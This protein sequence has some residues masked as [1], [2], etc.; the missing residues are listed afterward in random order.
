M[1]Q[2]IDQGS[3]QSVL[4]KAR[5][6]LSR[7][8]RVRA[9]VRAARRRLE[10]LQHADGHWC[11]EL[12]GDTILESE[13]VLCLFFLGL[14]TDEKVRKAAGYVRSA[15]LAGGGWS[16]YPG[17]PADVSVSIKAYLLLKLAGDDP[18]TPH[19]T[20]ARDRILALGGL[21]ACNS[22][23]KLYLSIFGQYEWSRAPAVVPE[24]ILLPRWFFCNIYA[25]SSWSRAIVVPLSMIWAHKP[26]CPLPAHADV[27]ELRLPRGRRAAAGGGLKARLWGAFFRTVETALTLFETLRFRPMRRR[28]M[29]R[30]EAWTLAHL[31]RSDGLGA[32]F[33]PIVNTLIALSCQGYSPDHP[34]MRRQLSE[35][36]KLEIEEP[37]TLRLQ[38]CKSP[39]WDTALALEALL[40]SG[41]RSDA[42]E[43]RAAARWL[44]DHEVSL[45]GDCQVIHPEI[46][47]GGWYFEYANEHYPDC[48]DTAK[49]LSNL[50]RVRFAE[51]DDDAKR[52]EAV[53]RGRA[54]LEAMQNADGGWA[55]FDKGCDREILTYI[56][57]AD[58][59]AMIDPSTADV[60]SRAVEALL[61][62]GADPAS[63]A[64][65]RAARFLRAEQEA[66]GSWYGRWGCNYVYGTWLAAQSLSRLGDPADGE[67]LERAAGWIRGVQ[68]ADGGWGE[69]PASYDDPAAKGIGPSTASQT[70]WALMALFAAG[71]FESDAAHRGVDYLLATQLPHG[72]WHDDPWTGTGFPKVFYLRYHLYATYFPLQALAA[73]TRHRHSE[74]PGGFDVGRRFRGSSP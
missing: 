21:D 2:E 7:R 13:Y 16:N 5:E 1:Y 54:W 65:A 37:D 73:W 50:S 63:P 58:H 68:N 40:E 71:D 22:F 27:S 52:R 34:V 3:G 15:Q 66:D 18:A 43:S 57:F 12:E 36:E 45:P 55:A 72:G 32:I 33:P 11:A 46:P 28:A 42:P 64:L 56:P 44:L 53:A 23:T 8:Q 25:M 35:L 6:V 49:V 70:A 17:G 4:A 19:M 60:T 48:D 74:K 38:P 20:A 30:A 14:A 67:R 51:A 10:S 62:L 41:T 31:E 61:A 47:V 9:S 69:L 26:H 39:V 29:H 24:M 59:N